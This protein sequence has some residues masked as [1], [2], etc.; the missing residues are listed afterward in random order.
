M[1]HLLIAFF[2]FHPTEERG[3]SER[4]TDNE[5]QIRVVFYQNGV[6]WMQFPGEQWETDQPGEDEE[7]L[8]NHVA[9]G[10]TPHRRGI[11]LEG[12]FCGDFSGTNILLY[13]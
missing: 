12:S 13:E 11:H 9:Q 3:E 1:M 4:D 7:N 6:V 10:P 8:E 5:D 2:D